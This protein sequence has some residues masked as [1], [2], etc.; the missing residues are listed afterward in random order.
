MRTR[1]YALK[2]FG[3]HRMGTKTQAKRLNRAARLHGRR[4]IRK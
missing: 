1:G 3:P 2:R 4:G